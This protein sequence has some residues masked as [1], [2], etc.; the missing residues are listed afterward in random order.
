MGSVMG[1]VCVF[2]FRLY[3]PAWKIVSTNIFN[4]KN[5]ILQCCAMLS[6]M[7]RA[8]QH[9]TSYNLQYYSFLN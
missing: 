4:N 7:T 8:M 5:Y 1:V 6:A 9:E 3:L 2:L